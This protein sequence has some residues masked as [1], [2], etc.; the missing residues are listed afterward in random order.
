MWTPDLTKRQGPLYLAV[1]DAIA[2]DISAQAL[3]P[4][5]RLPAQRELATALEIAIT[6]VTRAYTEAE[7]RGLVRGEVGRGT[8]VRGE[9]PDEGRQGS[10]GGSDERPHESSIADFRINS[11]L[12]SPYGREIL[13][14]VGRVAAE[15]DLGTLLD[16]QPLGGAEPQ[17][18]AGAHLMRQAGLQVSPDRVLVTSGAQHAMAITF[19]TL[20]KPGD[21]VLAEEFTYFGMKSLA[22]LLHIKLKGLPADE[23]GL[24]PDALAEACAAGD[25]KA[26]YTMPT[27]Q[28]P[29]STIMSEGRRREV[30]AIAAEHGVPIVEDDSYG[31]LLPDIK[32]LA[33][34]SDRTYYLCGTSKSLV[35]GL[36]IGFLAPPAGMRGQL[37]EAICSTIW[38]ASPLMANL[39]TRWIFD[40]TAQRIMEWK[41]KE[42]TARQETAAAILRGLD[43]QSHR[44]SPHGLLWL[45]ESWATADFVAQAAMRGVRISPVEKFVSSR[46]VLR[47]GVRIC[48]GPV[49][50]RRVLER[51]LTTL[52]E[53]A[54]EP[55]RAFE[56]V[57]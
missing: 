17:R 24:R 14:S 5:D 35:A 22:G 44:A 8:F 45:P 40:G 47:N 39:A 53:V 7:R 19:A 32:P 46:T 21:T 54:A 26:L 48:L 10:G 20:T 29:T 49:P 4:G 18:A 51:G 16:Y 36:R 27:L 1:A 38:M 43:Y 13:E 31:F 28:N 52:S 56:A 15:G 33:A 2:E 6:T 3:S 50:N 42:L 34:F 30:A 37:E 23:E 57:V 41:R 9:G 25:A 11:L 12:P 55:P